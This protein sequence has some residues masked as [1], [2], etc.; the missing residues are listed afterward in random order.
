MIL[1][2]TVNKLRRNPERYSCNS[3]EGKKKQTE[4]REIEETKGKQT[5]KWQSYVL[6]Y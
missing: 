2:S 3:Q 6:T 4:E 5:I 1:K